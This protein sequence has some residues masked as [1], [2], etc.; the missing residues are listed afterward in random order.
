MRGPSNVNLGLWR[1]IREHG[2]PTIEIVNASNEISAFFLERIL[3][4]AYCDIVYNKTKGGGGS[5]RTS[6]ERIVNK[7][8]HLG[9]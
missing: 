6:L 2:Q 3:V 4:A 7:Y 1:H 8:N 5:Y 9:D